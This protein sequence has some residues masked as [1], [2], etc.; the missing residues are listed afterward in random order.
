M[1]FVPARGW[2]GGGA[3]EVGEQ[4]RHSWRRRL[5]TIYVSWMLWYVLKMNVAREENSIYTKDVQYKVWRRKSPQSQKTGIRGF[6]KV[7]Y[8]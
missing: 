4:A 3:M 2:G 1:L 7:P 6:G 5:L 8:S